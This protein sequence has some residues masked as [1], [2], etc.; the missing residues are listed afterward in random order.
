MQI[1]FEKYG[2]RKSVYTWFRPSNQIRVPG[3]LS[4]E[5]INTRLFYYLKE[6][7]PSVRGANYSEVISTD[8]SFKFEDNED[9][10]A[11]QLYIGQIIDI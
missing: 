11:F 1:L 3:M 6:R 8:G 4:V 7:F 9:E 2:S 10:A 5:E